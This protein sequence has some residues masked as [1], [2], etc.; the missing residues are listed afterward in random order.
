MVELGCRRTAI[1]TPTSHP[2]SCFP[3]VWKGGDVAVKM[4]TLLFFMESHLVQSLSQVGSLPSHN[5]PIIS[6][7][8]TLSGS[9]R[10]T[11]GWWEKVAPGEPADAKT[12][13]CTVPK[14]QCPAQTRGAGWQD[15][16]LGCETAWAGPML[17]GSKWPNR[18]RV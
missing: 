16:S 15:I 1:P 3:G 13:M 11:S 7:S 10:P 17:I 4:R 5:H 2:I 6:N 18:A 12:C 8:Q 9:H 14:A